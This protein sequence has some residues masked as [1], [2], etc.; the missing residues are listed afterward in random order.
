[1]IEDDFA[2]LARGIADALIAERSEPRTLLGFFR[3]VAGGGRV[4][5]L[6]DQVAGKLVELVE[7]RQKE[8]SLKRFGSC[9]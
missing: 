6:R 8:K 2:E 1:M 4:N 9:Y 3:H 5:E 7:L